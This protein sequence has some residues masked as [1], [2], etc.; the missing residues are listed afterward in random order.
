MSV[1]LD[2]LGAEIRF[3]DTPTYGRVHI[4]EAGKGNAETLILMH[5]IGGHIE[6]YSKNVDSLSKDFT[7]SR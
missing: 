7:W 6:A 2:F 3:V 5:G 1:W 4:A